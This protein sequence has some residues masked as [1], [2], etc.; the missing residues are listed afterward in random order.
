M[1]SNVHGSW[2][3]TSRNAVCPLAS[4]SAQENPWT[5]F[6][7]KHKV[8]DVLSKAKFE[9]CHRIRICL[10]V[11]TDDLD[12]MV[13][14]SDISWEEIWLKKLSRL[15]KKATLPKAAKFSRSMQRNHALRLGIEAIDRRIAYDGKGPTSNTSAK[16]RQRVQMPCLTAAATASTGGIGKNQILL[17]VWFPKSPTGGIEV[18]VRDNLERLRSKKLNLSRDRCRTASR[19]F[20]RW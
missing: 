6:S 11:S 13:H 15:S 1:K 2:I 8:G 17:L 4:N 10:S 5:A 9:T 7:A 18:T 16:T 19:P 3:S 20:R 14:L 12:G